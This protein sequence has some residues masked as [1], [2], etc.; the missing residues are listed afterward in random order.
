MF[1]STVV[2]PGCGTQSNDGDALIKAANASNIRRLTN[3]YS[4]FALQH[5]GRGPKD[6]KEFRD[7]IVAIGPERLGRMGIDPNALDGLFVSERDSKPLVVRYA[8]KSQSGRD[9]RPS[10]KGA[11]AGIIVV[12]ETDGVDGRRQ[13]GFLGTREV[14]DL[15]ETQ[16]GAL[17]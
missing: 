11:A 8:Q 10:D 13:A 2:L 9:A 14:R 12:Q 5:N 17:Q 1:L 15:D 4:A 3:L 7:Y 16:A 6:E